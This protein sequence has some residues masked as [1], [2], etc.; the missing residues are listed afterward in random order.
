MVG[1]AQLPAGRDHLLHRA[2]AR[3][4]PLHHLQVRPRTHRRK[5]P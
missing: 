4:Q 5:P 1:Q 3:R 2:P